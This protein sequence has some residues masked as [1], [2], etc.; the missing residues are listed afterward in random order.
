MRLLAAIA[1]CAVT[2]FIPDAA[3]AKPLKSGARTHQATH[4]VYRT[5]RHAKRSNHAKR[6]Y[7]RSGHRYADGRPRAW[8]GWYMRQQV[9]SD[10]G[11]AY[12]LAR[13]WAHWGS[14]ASGP[15][16]D[17]V[18]VWGHHVGKIVGRTATGWLV[19]SGNDGGT[20]RTRE[21]SIAGAI[22]FRVSGGTIKQA[23]NITENITAPGAASGIA[24]IYW[25]GQK[26]ANGKR[27][28]VNA[29]TC[30]HRT[31]PL[32]SSLEVSSSKGTVRCLVADRGPFIRGRIVDL[33]PAAAQ[34]IGLTRQAGLARV[35]VRR[36]E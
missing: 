19:N 18:V 3:A 2:T 28:D 21:R 14:P 16:I 34:A 5:T 36:V 27:L 23:K 10:P 1:L 22:A 24:S 13:N 32:G 33:T 20:V 31:A 4:H 11:P 6:R 8:C 35:T 15:C 17:C 7:H 30:A 9:G 25:Q 26:M 12:N 29:L